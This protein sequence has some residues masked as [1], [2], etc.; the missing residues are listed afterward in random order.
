MPLLTEFAST[1][2]IGD[3]IDGAVG[4]EEREDGRTEAW[5]NRDAEASIAI[6][7][8]RGGSIERRVFVADNEHGDLG[9]ILAGIPHLRFQL[10]M[11]EA[12]RVVVK[13]YL[14]CLKLV[15]IESLD[16]GLLV[17]AKPLLLGQG[18]VVLGTRSRTGKS[19]HADKEEVLL[20]SRNDGR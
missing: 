10:S 9:A 7:E 14:L 19:S 17:D 6:L 5:V 13:T 11:V 15:G 1:T 12:E 4:L 20:F 16:L 18:E 3:R 8:C 2:N